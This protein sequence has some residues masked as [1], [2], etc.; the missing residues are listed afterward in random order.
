MSSSSEKRDFS[1]FPFPLSNSLPSDLRFEE[2][3][4]SGIST[5]ESVSPSDRAGPTISVD[6]RRC[7]GLLRRE[8]AFDVLIRPYP[9]A[10]SSYD[11]I[12]VAGLLLPVTFSTRHLR[13]DD[14]LM[15]DARRGVDAR[16]DVA[17]SR[18]A[19]FGFGRISECRGAEL[20]GTSPRQLH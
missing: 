12:F 16:F 6:V 17:M 18:E 11:T 14:G 9:S 7:A 2:G 13:H 5:S 1:I 19:R 10:V 8:L 15:V 4:T 3:L 20:V